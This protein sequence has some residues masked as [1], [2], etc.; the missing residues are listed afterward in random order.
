ML[1]FP[2][3]LFS[4]FSFTLWFF[5][6]FRLLVCGIIFIISYS[7][8]SARVREKTAKSDKKKIYVNNFC[9][10]LIIKQIFKLLTVLTFEVKV[11]ESE[12]I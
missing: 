3:V 6:Y 11:V 1:I 10:I 12:S 2:P 7:F 5:A 9:F 4:F 8:S